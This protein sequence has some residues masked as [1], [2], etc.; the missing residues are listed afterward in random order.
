MQYIKWKHDKHIS[1]ATVLRAPNLPANGDTALHTS[2]AKD[3]LSNRN[4][5][6]KDWNIPCNHFVFAQQTHSDHFYK[7]T[8]ADCGKGT[9]AY[10]DGIPDCDA[11]YTR[12]SNIA[13][14]I[15]HADCVP[16]LLYDPIT[17]VI[18]AI[19]S[20]WQGTIKEIT[21]KL[22]T[23]LMEVEGV[24]PQNLQAYIGPAIAYQSFEVGMDVVEK[25]QAISFDTTPF[26]TFKTDGKALVDNK[27]LNVQMLKNLGV[28]SKNITIDKNDTFMNNEAFF[29]YRR[30]KHCGRHM[31]F[32]ILHT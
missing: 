9:K 20:G 21:R 18:A 27:M 15:F 17:H 12:E 24:K 22:A 16:I 10:E 1:A 25:V 5:V 6:S 4:I 28:P 19:H 2:N 29:S 3:V 23:H 30:D 26:I 8:Q 13:L 31:S 7:V 14:G 32:I 11:L